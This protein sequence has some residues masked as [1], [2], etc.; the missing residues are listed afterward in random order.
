MSYPNTEEMDDSI[1]SKLKPL[2]SIKI[3]IDDIDNEINDSRPTILITNIINIEDYDLRS[4]FI[5]QSHNGSNQKSQFLENEKFTKLSYSM[6]MEEFEY[7]SLFKKLN[8][9]KINV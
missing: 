6:M 2:C 8:E 3:Q 4:N 5:I 1:N 7:C 9:K